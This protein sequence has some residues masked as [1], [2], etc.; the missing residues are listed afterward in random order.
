MTPPGAGG[1]AAARA[2]AAAARAAAAAAAQLHLAPAQQALDPF[3]VDLHNADAHGRH[4][5]PI[6]AAAAL[7]RAAQPKDVGHRG[8][9]N[10][11]VAVRLAGARLAVEKDRACGARVHALSARCWRRS[12]AVLPAAAAAGAPPPARTVA[13][14]ARRVHHIA[15]PR[16]RVH[17][18]AGGIRAK[19]AG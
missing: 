10:P 14:L 13:A 7:A 8:A 19:R 9:R 3:A 18:L 16:G 4:L 11:L 15:R 12:A 1:A 6:T 5:A 17:L 2:A